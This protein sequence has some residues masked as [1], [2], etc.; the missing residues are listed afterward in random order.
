MNKHLTILAF[1]GVLLSFGLF[2]ANAWS[3]DDKICARHTIAP[4]Y[5]R[6]A[7]LARITGTVEVDVEVASD[8]SVHS[9]IGSGAQN[10]L[11]RAAEE[12]VKRWTFC[13][14]VVGVKLRIVYAYRL[15]GRQEYDDTPAKV[16]FHLPQVE[17]VAH[18]PKPRGY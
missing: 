15:E 18:P 17:I 11:D 6:L 16:L 10:L 2:H 5:P 14:G 3:A 8:G 4:T 1:L 7:R 12:N 9:A 13:S